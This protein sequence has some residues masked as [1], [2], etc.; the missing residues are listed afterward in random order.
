MVMRADLIAVLEVAGS[1]I[2]A[3]RG[4]LR[5]RR[6][7]RLLSRPFVHTPYGFQ[8]SGPKAMES[9]EFE[10]T[11]VELFSSL[12]QN[13]DGFVN[14]GANFGYYVCM[15]LAHGVPTIAIEPSPENREILNKN[16]RQN[17]FDKDVSVMP[18]AC[19]EAEG[20]A[21]IFG[22]GTGASLVDGWARNPKSLRQQIPVQ[23]LD[24]IVSPGS[25]TRQSL[26]LVDVEGFELEVMK[27][28]EKILER[29]EKPIWIIESGLFS[30]RKDHPRNESFLPLVQLM[31][32]FGYICYAGSDLSKPIEVEF[33]EQEL[34]EDSS[35][36][37]A[38][39]FL[40]TPRDDVMR[41]H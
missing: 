33:I 28:A 36:L 17:G 22:V 13:A 29:N 3:I 30:H 16:L 14:V 40:F 24:K 25:I 9:G 23:R 15:A 10:R 37:S 19:G 8:F 1:M 20:E 26:F 2:D 4:F 32:E 31:N 34:R 7:N 38:I 39:N 27:G 18:L 5:M 6:H 35:Q 12:I 21:V 11:E 41:S